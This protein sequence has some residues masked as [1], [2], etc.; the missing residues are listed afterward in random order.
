MALIGTLRYVLCVKISDNFSL[1]QKDNRP[2]PVLRL[3][4]IINLD[5]SMDT[6]CSHSSDSH[7]RLCC[8]FD[9][10]QTWKK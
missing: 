4:K 2:C 9:P 8:L 1:R 7:G 6:F 3:F 10:E 5:F